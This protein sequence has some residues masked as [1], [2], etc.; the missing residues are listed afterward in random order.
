MYKFLKIPNDQT[1]L[2]S[3]T[4]NLL[5]ILCFELV[6]AFMEPLK[7]NFVKKLGINHRM[8]FEFPLLN[9]RMKSPQLDN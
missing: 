4:L 1:F 2:D 3:F 6:Y 9:R 5:I 8:N 7:S